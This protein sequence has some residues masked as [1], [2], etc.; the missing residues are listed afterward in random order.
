IRQREPLVVRPERPASPRGRPW[1]PGI[2]RHARMCSPPETPRVF[3]CHQLTMTYQSRIRIHLKGPGAV[4]STGRARTSPGPCEV[5]SPSGREGW[6]AGNPDEGN[7]IM[8]AVQLPDGEPADFSRG[9]VYFIGNATTL[10][11]FGGITILT[12]PAFL[13]RGA[14]VDLGHGIW[15]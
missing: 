9:E 7:G 8:T 14:H 6:W 1:H 5:V 2:N 4:P 10:I 11:R 13:H 12:D 15:A 3:A